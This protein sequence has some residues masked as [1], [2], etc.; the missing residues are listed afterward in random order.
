MSAEWID[1]V[2][3]DRDGLVPAIAQ[4]A[5]SGQV[6]MVAWM[7][8]EALSETVNTGRAVY[9]SRS[10]SRL[11]RKGEESGHVQLVKQVFLDCDGDVVLLKVDQT[12]GIACHTGRA[13][14]FFR[15]LDAGQWVV[16]QPVLRDPDQIYRKS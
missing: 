14:C 15:K 11:W 12:G 2:A 5:V 4:D 8:R 3:W 1:E 7:D 10:R 9:W 13:S 6:L 16:T